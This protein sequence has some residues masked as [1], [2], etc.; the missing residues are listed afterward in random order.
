MYH[1]INDFLTEWEY[2]SNSTIQVFKNIT[3][4]IL[5]KKDF[6][7]IRSISILC[8][9]ITITLSEMMNRTGLSVIGPDEHSIPPDH[10]E[11]IIRVYQESAKSVSDQVGTKWRDEILTE[12]VD[13]YGENWKKGVV[14]SI[15]IR[16]QAH[17][18]GQLTILMRQAGL[19]VPG[20]Y[21]PSKEE[22][23]GMNLTA[24]E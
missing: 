20:V 7:N 14:L 10:I 5:L 19:K 8:W 3:D 12:E 11:E 18:R 24:P 6:E 21:G 16:H 9:H 15:L 1:K 13:M 17:H 22:W 23:L 2:E 4:E